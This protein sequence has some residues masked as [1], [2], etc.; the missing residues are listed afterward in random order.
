[1]I[2]IASVTFGDNAGQS[3]VVLQHDLP[4]SLIVSVFNPEIA[5]T[6]S[7]LTVSVSEALGSEDIIFLINNVEVM[8]YAP[9]STGTLSLV[10]VPVPPGDAGS[11][12]LTVRQGATSQGTASFTVAQPYAPPPV[13]TGPDAPPVQVPGAIQPNGVRRWVFQDLMPGGL[14][15][16]VMPMNPATMGSPAFTRE[17]NVKK[18]T[19]S[20]AQGGQFHI[21]ADAFTPVPWEFS[22]Y[23]PTDEMRD[24]L[25]AYHALNR[26]WYLHDHR[27]R[28]W[29]VVLQDLELEA[30]LTQYWNGEMTHEGHDYTGRLMVLDRDW[31]VV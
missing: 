17:L 20:T 10:S 16:W 19:A 31:T 9:D 14:G 13:R 5:V 28:A 3:N 25:E 24:K 4:S 21:T 18:T 15:S 2:Q 22:G 27:G 26:R 12:T 23:A 6:P 7:A 11:F 1:M 29:K 30:R 8:R